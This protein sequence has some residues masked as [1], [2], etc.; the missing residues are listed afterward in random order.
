M[1]KIILFIFLLVSNIL[2]AQISK[3]LGDFSKVTAFDKISI[4][5]VS[6]NENRIE[7]KGDLASEVQIITKNKELKIRM[8]LEH[9]MKGD[10]VNVILYFKKLEAIEANEGSSISCDSNLKALD[11][12]L[13]AKEGADIKVAIDAQRITLKSSNGAVITLSGKAQNLE[14][15]VSSGGILEAQKLET[16]QT[17]ISVN[18]GGN[19]DV[20]ATDL[21]DAKVRAGGN[22]T[23]YG[24]PKQVNQK[25]V[26]AGNIKI[27]KNN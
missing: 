14:A 22:I 23:I 4:K 19:A 2:L 27:I 13:I 25:T 7:I 20:F 1:K 11:F 21:V 16:N 6:S 10:D 17:V 12:N 26:I 3:S 8:P 18:A 9:L 15:I 5:L 24:N